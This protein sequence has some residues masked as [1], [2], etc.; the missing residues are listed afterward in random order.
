MTN[1]REHPESNCI[2]SIVSGPIF[3]AEWNE[4]EQVLFVHTCAGK[5]TWRE[6]A[7]GLRAGANTRIA[8]KTHT[9]R[10]LQMP[11]SLEALTQIMSG[12]KVVYDP[13][14]IFTRAQLLVQVAKTI[15]ARFPG[16]VAGCYI[17]ASSRA[18]LLTPSERTAAASFAQLSR[19]ASAILAE[20]DGKGELVGMSVRV[21]PELPQFGKWLAVDGMS[22]QPTRRLRSLLRGAI[23]AAAS[24][25]LLAGAAAHA[26]T[27]HQD[28]DV[29]SS[30]SVFADGATNTTSDNFVSA[31]LAFY[32]GEGGASSRIEVQLAQGS[33]PGLRIVVNPERQV[34]D[35]PELRRPS[36]APY[37]TGA[38]PGS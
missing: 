5:A 17:H 36:W 15:R 25:S 8:I 4:T 11:R 6:L 30:L 3:A 18:L 23:A 34:E 32:F 31:G 2:A 12:G 1:S 24:T 10:A 9:R 14:Q 21:L 35:G 20:A 22:V 16:Q 19:E 13:T 26:G 28:A 38:G 37:T 29:L 33:S 27:R 7:P